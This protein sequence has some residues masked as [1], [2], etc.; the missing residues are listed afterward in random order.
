MQCIRECGQCVWVPSRIGLEY[1]VMNI[2]NRNTKYLVHSLEL[3]ENAVFCITSSDHLVYLGTMEGSCFV[4]PIDVTD[5][6]TMP[7]PHYVYVSDNSIDGL[8]LSQTFL[9]LSTRNHI[10]FLNP[11]TLVFESVLKRTKNTQ[12]FVGKMMLSDNGDMMWSA[13]LGGVVLSAWN[14]HECT[15]ITYV[16]VNI[17][18]EEKCHIDD[19][20]DRIM[21]A[22]CV[23]LDTVWV[24]L[25]SGYFMVFAMYPPGELLTYFRPYNS[26]IRFLSA[27]KYPGPCQKEEC[28]MLYGGKMYRP[29]DRFKELPDCAR[30]GEM[31]KPV[32]TAGVAV[33]WEVLPAKYTRQ[34]HYLSAGT[35][36]L[37]Y[38]TLEKAMNDTGFTDSMQYCQSA[39]ANSITTATLQDDQFTGSNTSSNTL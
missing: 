1:G 20:Q 13:H 33:L 6:Q 26:Y 8:A 31:G 39:M 37:N 2:F 19:Y 18:A 11:E 35:S 23:A 30:E 38:S 10:Y 29:D 14:D 16:D 32:D 15:H 4:F 27:S 12:A 17:C 25:S 5:I 21:T 36:W 28:L 9:W 22:M 7:Q 34:I 3:R 24:G